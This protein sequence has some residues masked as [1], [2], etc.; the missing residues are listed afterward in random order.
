MKLIA[1]LVLFAS[2]S[3]SGC[4]GTMQ[5]AVRGGGD[6]VS[7]AYEQGFDSDT[8]TATVGQ[9]VFK[10]RAVFVDNAATF[11]TVFGSSLAGSDSAFGSGNIFGVSMSGKAKATLLGNQGSTM[12]CFLEYAD[13]TGFTTSGGVGE[14]QHSDGRMIDV[15]W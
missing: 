12:R 8:L 5:A 10:G 14:C 9:E 1:P 15:V 13:P 3:V 7:F 2:I 4:A 11:G 6:A